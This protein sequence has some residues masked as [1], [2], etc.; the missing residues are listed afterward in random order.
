[1]V[2]RSTSQGSRRRG[3]WLLWLLLVVALLSGTTSCG[4]DPSVLVTVIG[5]DAS[6]SQLVVTS[7]LD[8]E[9][10]LDKQQFPVVPPYFYLSLPSGS[11]GQLTVVVDA[12]DADGCSRSRGRGFVEMG[13]DGHA[14]VDV[15]LVAQ[16][17]VTCEVNI[18]LP[19]HSLSR[20]AST[21]GR[22]SCLGSCQTAVITGTALTLHVEEVDGEHLLGFRLPCIGTA[23]C[24]FVVQ[25][26]VDVEV[27][28]VPAWICSPDA[29]CWGSS[30]SSRTDAGIRLLSPSDVQ[31]GGAAIALYLDGRAGRG[32]VAPS[33]LPLSAV[34]GS[35]ANQCGRSGRKGRCLRSMATSGVSRRVA[36]PS[37]SMASGE[38]DPATSMPSEKMV[39]CS[40]LTAKPGPRCRSPQ[41]WR[42]PRFGAPVRRMC[43]GTRVWQRG[44]ALRWTDVESGAATQ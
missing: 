37:G 9:Q 15:F 29:I 21:D 26:S 2:F 6:T 38:V 28:V 8:G 40:T 39:R 17:N 3:C 33:R 36:R 13:P 41:R 42:F 19:E 20:V 23:P 24:S 10:V 12:Q 14:S 27:A 35:S 18:H 44:V 1:M 22:L 7:R 31:D 43:V 25:K 30:T 32:L 11:R 34:W 5:I 16:P 4:S